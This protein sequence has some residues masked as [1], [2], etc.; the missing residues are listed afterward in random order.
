MK[1]EVHVKFHK[2]YLQVEGSTIN[3]GISV[4]PEKGK[5]NEEIIKKLAKHF[6]VAKSSIRIIVGK[7][8]RNKI[9]E[10]G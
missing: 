4:C 1:Y 9:I 7:T 3:I 5:A 8:S 10:I 6:K 2:N